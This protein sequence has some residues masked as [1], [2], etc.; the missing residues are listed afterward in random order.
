MLNFPSYAKHENSD[1]FEAKNQK[2]EKPLLLLRKFFLVHILC[3]NCERRRGQKLFWNIQLFLCS[4]NICFTQ[5]CIPL[6]RSRPFTCMLLDPLVQVE[7][8]GKG[9]LLQNN[10]GNY[11]LLRLGSVTCMVSS[12]AMFG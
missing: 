12:L 9:F 11:L 7:Q 6:K 4:T 5:I 3:H 10:L 2:V 1:S 8:K